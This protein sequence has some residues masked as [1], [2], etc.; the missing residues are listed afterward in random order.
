MCERLVIP[1]QQEVEHDIRVARPWWSFSTRFNVA[2]TQSVPVARLHEKDSEGV[3]MRWGLVPSSTKGHEVTIGACTIDSG[4]IEASN[5]YRSV[6]MCGQRCIVPVAGFYVWH[7]ASAGHRQPFYVRLVNRPVFG[8]AALWD[9]FVTDQDDVIEG[10]A[11]ITVP[12]NDLIAGID[13][14]S[15][16]MPAILNRDDYAGWLS[17]KPARAKGLLRVYPMD[18]MVTHAVGPHVNFLKYDDPRLIR[19]VS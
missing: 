1:S 18:L 10:C 12:A 2:V 11:L 6:W 5:D 3:M 9:R 14:V 16:R 8:V 13:N 15:L 19:P 7:R 4:E 17:A